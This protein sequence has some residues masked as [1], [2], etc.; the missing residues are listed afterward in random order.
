MSEK[1]PRPSAE[2]RAVFNEMVARELWLAETEALYGAEVPSRVLANLRRPA[3]TNALTALGILAVRR[4][5]IPLPFKFSF[6][7]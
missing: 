3:I 1:G 6:A 7:A 5:V 4:K 2:L